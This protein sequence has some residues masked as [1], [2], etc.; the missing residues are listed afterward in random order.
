M[1]KPCLKQLFEQYEE[2]QPFVIDVQTVPGSETHRY[3][4]ID[5]GSKKGR[6]FQVNSLIEKSQQGTAPSN[7]AIMGR[8]ILR[9]EIMKFL[10]EQNVGAGGEIQLTDAIQKLNEI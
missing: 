1:K 3:G 8:Y 5:L 4:I 10:E 2:T 9:P 7:L 6:R